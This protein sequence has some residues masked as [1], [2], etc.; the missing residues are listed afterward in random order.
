VP[1]RNGEGNRPIS[2][3]APQNLADAQ[4]PR[5]DV[6]RQRNDTWT[7]LVRKEKGQRLCEA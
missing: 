3:E 7:K 2:K 4:S 1:A 6:S 5:A